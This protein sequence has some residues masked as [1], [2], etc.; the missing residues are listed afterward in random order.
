M[1]YK[2]EGGAVSAPAAAH[3]SS[4]TFTLNPRTDVHGDTATSKLAMTTRANYLSTFISLFSFGVNPYRKLWRPTYSQK[5]KDPNSPLY[6]LEEIL[7]MAPP[8][9]TAESYRKNNRN[10]NKVLRTCNVTT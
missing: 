4:L 9:I 7:S 6:P 2:L 8:F 10:K 1:E 3:Q 5:V